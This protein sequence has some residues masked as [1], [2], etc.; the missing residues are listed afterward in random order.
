MLEYSTR[1]SPAQNNPQTLNHYHFAPYSQHTIESSRRMAWTQ[2]MTRSICASCSVSG[3]RRGL[4]NRCTKASRRFWRN[5]DSRSKF[6]QAKT[7]ISRSRQISALTKEWDIIQVCS[8]TRVTRP[9][10]TEGALLSIRYMMRTS[11]I[12]NPK[13]CAL[14]R[15]RPRCS[16][17]LE[18]MRAK[19]TD[20]Q[21]RPP[22]RQ[23]EYLD[24][25]RVPNPSPQKQGEVG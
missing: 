9:A 7:E 18:N 20:L 15:E 10:M 13:P 21:G 1:L 6:I 8:L 14:R 4:T 25:L 3:I 19:G 23:A 22:K 2:T 16:I 11:R 24:D 17:L 12:S 5:S